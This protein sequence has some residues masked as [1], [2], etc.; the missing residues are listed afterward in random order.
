MRATEIT[1][2]LAKAGATM[3][4]Q[5]GSHQRWR[6]TDRGVTSYTT[7]PMHRGD[8]P[9]GTVR[10]IEKDMERSLGKGWLLR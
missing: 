6:V 1:T 2:T 5:R 4:R 10:Q 9:L 3:I 8:V 7:V